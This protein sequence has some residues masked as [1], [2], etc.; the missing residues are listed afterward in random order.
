MESAQPPKGNPADPCLMVIFGAS[1]D[2]TKRKVIPALYNLSQSSYLPAN[3][4][5][6]GLAIDSMDSEKFRETMTEEVRDLSEAP[7][8]T[9][10]WKAFAQKLYYVQGS[11][12]DSAAYE[13]L[14]A[15][16]AEVAASHDTK[17]NYLFYLATSPSFFSLVVD[18][19]GRAG[20]VKQEEGHWRRVIIEKPFGHD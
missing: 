1:G 3:F 13:R 15:K 10:S 12:D 19:L 14:R 8:E 11:F 4:A 17:G 18:Q 20:L 2:L 7:V 16:I 9:D 6:I 5:V